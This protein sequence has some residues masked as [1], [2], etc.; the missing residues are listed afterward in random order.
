MGRRKEAV[1]QH[2][3]RFSDLEVWL[4]ART[5]KARVHHKCVLT[6][7]HAVS[8]ECFAP[9]LP[10]TGKGQGGTPN[11]QPPVGTSRARN[12][13]Y[14][15]VRVYTGNIVI[16]LLGKAAP[17]SLLDRLSVI[18]GLIFA[19]NSIPDPLGRS[20][21]RPP[22]GSLRSTVAIMPPVVLV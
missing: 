17:S 21:A 16:P 1:L 19:I 18:R 13:T 7:P 5:R 6:P 4:R 22:I 10:I 3:K 2:D 15:R 8:T 11:E 20:V 9:R 12:N 14:L